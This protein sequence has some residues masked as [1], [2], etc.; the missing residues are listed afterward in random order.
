MSNIWGFIMNIIKG[1]FGQKTDSK[2]NKDSWNNKWKKS[3]I[4]YNGRALRGKKKKIAID[5]KAFIIKEDEI[6]K[7]VVKRNHLIKN[8]FDDTALAIQQ[9]VVRF[10]TYKYDDENSKVPEFWQFP[11]ETLQSEI[12]DCEDGAILISSLLINSGIPSWRVKVGAGYVQSSPTA[13]QGG[14][15]YCL[16]LA[17]DN[18]WRI[19]DWCY[20]QDSRV[21]VKDKPLAK[22]GG[23]R[24]AY[25]D[26]WF[27]FNNENSWAGTPIEVFDSRMSKHMTEKKENVLKEEREDEIE[28]M[29]EKIDKKVGKG[30]LNSHSI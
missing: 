16:Y 12:G 29:M 4:I 8:N 11:F 17:D 3:P 2:A 7:K 18:E 22:N 28:K 19:L 6:L 14:H 24:G 13:P 5:V 1:L 27:T 26:I 25:K 30:N 9:W 23:Q 10:L 21:R 20:L 15:A